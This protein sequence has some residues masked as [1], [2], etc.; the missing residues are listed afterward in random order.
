LN[1]ELATAFTSKNR[2]A[3]R[4]EEALNGRL[5]TISTELDRVFTPIP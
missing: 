5:L 4:K 3:V 2:L 1:L